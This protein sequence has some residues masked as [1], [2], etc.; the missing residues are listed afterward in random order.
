MKLV[1]V[2]STF[3]DMQYERDLLQTYAIPTLNEQLRQYGEKAYFGDLRWGVNTTDLDSDEGSRKVLK[4]CLDQ[5]DNCKPYMIVLVGERYG[6]IPAQ[7]L[8][9]EACVL[10][11]IEKIKDISVT[12]LEIDYG[13]LLNP[14]YEGR[15]LF[16]F[17]NLD[18]SGMIDAQRRDYEAESDRHLEKV[19]EL[20]RR[21]QE[22]YP[23]HVR[24]YDA[25]WDPRAQKVVGL[26]GFLSQ[27]QT[28]LGHVL[29][30]DL[31]AENNL[32]WQQRSMQAAHRYFTER[33]KTLVNTANM[34]EVYCGSQTEYGYP[35]MY[36][37]GADGS[38]K[39]AAVACGYCACTGEKLAFSCGLDAFS[40]DASDFERILIYKMEEMCGYLHRD[41]ADE[42]LDDEV[43]RL[44][45]ALP[46]PLSV[47]VDNADGSFL[48]FLSRLE[49]LCGEE[50]PLSEMNASFAIAVQKDLPFFPFFPYSCKVRMSDLSEEDAALVL[51]GIVRSHHKEVADV[52]K[53][54]IL[55]KESRG[56]ASYLR[57][58]V[59]R[60]MILDSEDFAAIRAMGDGMDNINR[61]M[62][63]IVDHTAD[64][65]YAILTELIDEAKER[66]N[67]SFVRRII[68]VFVHVPLGLSIEDFRGIFAA[69]GWEFNDLDFSLAV[70]MLED[71]LD[72]SP[73][74][75]FY[76]I[77]NQ[78]IRDGIYRPNAAWDAVP[79]AEYMLAN[80]ELRPYAFKA[81]VLD[82]DPAY[83]CTVLERSGQT[84][85]TDSIAYLIRNELKDR[86]I[87]ILLVIG[88]N[89]AF[90]DVKLLPQFA[91]FKPEQHEY[92]LSFFAELGDACDRLAGEGVS[93][94]L[95]LLLDA[96]LAVAEYVLPHIPNA[97]INVVH[98]AYDKMAQRTEKMSASVL[99]RMFFLLLRAVN[100]TRSQETFEE[101]IGGEAFL[102]A[103]HY[104][105]AYEET[106]LKM[107]VYKEFAESV[108]TVDEEL[109]QVYRDRAEDL[110]VE[111]DMNLST[112]EDCIYVAQ[113]LEARE[114]LLFG[115]ACYPY[116]LSLLRA[117]VAMEIGTDVA[118]TAD[119]MKKAETIWQE[120]KMVE[121]GVIYW[122]AILYHLLRMDEADEDLIEEYIALAG[123]LVRRGMEVNAY[124]DVL[125]FAELLTYVEDVESL[126]E[127]ICTDDQDAEDYAL[128]MVVQDMIR[129]YYLED[130]EEALRRVNARYWAIRDKY[131]GADRVATLFIEEYMSRMLGEE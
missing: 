79:V 68:D 82:A 34:E 125:T 33:N 20:K 6:W 131:T 90:W 81:A 114:W 21:I 84:D 44:L 39:T 47:Y 119:T 113:L 59:K 35:M 9:D 80:E 64:D 76:R 37:T 45:T 41:C 28:D 58:V 51:D 3:K 57:S 89:D 69:Y 49:M 95:M 60:L 31:E 50:Q 15:I 121:D 66:I 108:E 91:D 26:E 129:C 52:V 7:E 38:G 54:R 106:F 10:K 124:V 46:Q 75:R 107:K 30:R 100:K 32:P 24:Y 29:L 8:I 122:R 2:S 12:E 14:E 18:K 53:A 97:T 78:S 109:A 87:E 16:Y 63:S 19:G 42:E 126:L 11:G 17:R 120:T 77:K 13:A 118:D 96:R 104:T 1:F 71:V 112:A 48:K 94:R 102:N 123:V 25:T 74:T 61:Y 98:A 22:V 65:Q 55:S 99:N 23:N 36:I 5:I 70:Q 127:A 56:S 86:A 83:L 115:K 4:V 101:Y 67:R 117:E 110:A 40:R 92:V 85:I 72:Y 128:E 43:L 116:D 103:F 111:A 105:D 130:D 73:D 62:L 88:E 27:V 93:L